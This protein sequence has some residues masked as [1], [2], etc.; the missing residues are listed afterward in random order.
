MPMA[1]SSDGLR[2]FE[3]SAITSRKCFFPDKLAGFHR[4]GAVIHGAPSLINA[5]KIFADS[6]RAIPAV[7]HS[8]ASPSMFFSAGLPSSSPRLGPRTAARGRLRIYR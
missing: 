5:I 7:A 1:S 8:S 3:T 4:Q 2:F 6:C